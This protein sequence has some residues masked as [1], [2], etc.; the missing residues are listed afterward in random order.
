[1]TTYVASC[2]CCFFDITDSKIPCSY[3]LLVPTDMQSTPMNGF[4]SS[5]YIF[6][7][8]LKYSIGLNPE[9]SAKVIG[10]SSK[11]SAN[12]LTAYC[13]IPSI[14]SAY[15]ETSIAQ[16]S[17]VAPPPPTTLLFLTM[18]LTTQMASNK[19]LFASSHI[20]LDPPLIK[21]VTAF[22]FSHS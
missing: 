10:I 8:L 22:E 2:N 12:A 11:A 1:M 20:V 14:L 21:T 5:I 4:Y 6:F 15:Y 16:A 18:F 13:S 7:I 3:I 17:S 19:H 9:F